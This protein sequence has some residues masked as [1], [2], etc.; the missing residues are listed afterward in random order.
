MTIV[1][2]IKIISYCLSRKHT[3]KNNIDTD[4]YYCTTAWLSQTVDSHKDVCLS[5]LSLGKCIYRVHTKHV[6]L[7]FFFCLKIV[8]LFEDCPNHF[9]P[10]SFNALS[11]HP[12]ASYDSFF[13]SLLC[14]LRQFLPF[15]PV[16]LTTV[17]PVYLTTVPSLHSCASYDSSVPSPVYLTIVSTLHLCILRHFLLFPPVYTLILPPPSSVCVFQPLPWA[18]QHNTVISC[19][20]LHCYPSASMFQPP[21]SFSSP[22]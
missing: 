11:L 20:P 2:R 12:Y 17:P 1:L 7:M 5:I 21:V 10:L 4:I 15:T 9:T 22:F 8:F 16:Y 14:I 13:P 6:K 18:A 3:E 19:S